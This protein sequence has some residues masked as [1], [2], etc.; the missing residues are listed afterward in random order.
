MA[1][2]QAVEA[3]HNL[4]LRCELLCCAVQVIYVIA[5][6]NAS[7]SGMWVLHVDYNRVVQFDCV[8]VAHI[9]FFTMQ[10]RDFRNCA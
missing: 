7:V 4:E 5:V 6:G 1:V 9:V 2:V 3:L 8:F 10:W